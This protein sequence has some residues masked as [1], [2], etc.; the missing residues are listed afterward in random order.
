M[1]TYK[2]T[3]LEKIMLELVQVG[4]WY[5][6]SEKGNARS[7]YDFYANILIENDVDIEHQE[8]CYKYWEKLKN[9]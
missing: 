9:E 4:E 5:R 1:K 3:K 8:N 7:H 2:Q 6:N